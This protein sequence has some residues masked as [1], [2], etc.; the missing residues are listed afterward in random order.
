MNIYKLLA[1]AKRIR[2][3]RLKL[4]GLWWFH[5]T[6]RRYLGIFID[7]VLSCN[8]RCQMCYFSDPERRKELHGTFTEAQLEQLANALFHRA[9]KLQIGC[10][11][12]PTLYR[13]LPALIR[14]GRAHRVPFISVT[15][16]GQLLDEQRLEELIEAGLDE[17]TL[18]LHG[19]TQ[20]TYE[21][22][23]QGASFERFQALLQAL[24]TVGQRH[25][26][27]HVR[28]NYTMNADNK[29]EV[30]LLPQLFEGVPVSVVQLRP[31]QRIGDTAYQDFSVA[32]LIEDYDRLFPPLVQAL[33]Q[34]G[35]QCLYPTKENLLALSPIPQPNQQG[36]E[37]GKSREANM[38]LALQDFSYCNL[39]PT[40]QWQEDFDA[41]RDT[42]E[43]YCRRHHRGRQML[44]QALGFKAKTSQTFLTKQLNYTIK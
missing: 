3:P 9:L 44:A 24:R 10:G 13:A 4:L 34:Q 17:L 20:A 33:R 18:S 37:P 42:F 31:I 25:P 2:S 36:K 40:L 16:N 23:M 28:V 5:T 26:Q 35:I 38:E 43:S 41:T 11:A 21:R 8:L 32:P 7:P 22:L 6:G 39:T 12:E 27:F 19:T 1:I 29:D 30:A 15:T 14:L